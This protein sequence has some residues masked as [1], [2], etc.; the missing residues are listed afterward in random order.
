MESLSSEAKSLALDILLD[1]QSAIE[2]LKERTQHIYDVDDF[3]GNEY[4][5]LR[6]AGEPLGGIGGLTDSLEGVGL[7]T[8]GRQVDSKA[9]LA[10][11]LHRVFDGVLDEVL[12][13]ILRPLGIEYRG[14][15]TQL[16]PQ[17]L[18]DMGC[19]G[20]YKHRQRLQHIATGAL[21][22]TQLA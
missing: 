14:V 1:I 11:E 12:R 22:V 10:V 21:E 20:S 2:K 6:L 9:H 8:V 4:N 17:L 5:F 19:K 16:M 18:G 15:M 3:L 13:V 7:G